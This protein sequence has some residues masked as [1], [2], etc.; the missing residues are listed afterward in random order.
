MEIREF[1]PGD[2]QAILDL[3][4]V[5]FGKP[6]SKEF[7]NWRYRENPFSET[8]QAH[9]MWDNNKLVG[10]YAVC[11]V[12]MII[13]EVVVQTA[14]SMTT[15]THPEYTGRGIFKDLAESLYNELHTNHQIQMVWGFPNLN[16]H[17]GFVKNLKWNDVATVPT[18][19][20]KNR[21]FSSF[22]TNDY[23]LHENFTDELVNHLSENT[24][25]IVKLDKTMDYLNWRYKLNPI[26][27]YYIISPEKYPEQF[28]VIKFF[29]S[30]ENPEMQEIDILELG[31]DNNSEILKELIGAILKFTQHQN[32][33]ILSINSWLNISDS[34][35]MLLEKNKFILDSPITILGNRLL[36]R[37][38]SSS[39]KHFN[40]WSISMGDSDVY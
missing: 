15:M 14:L 17:Y 5:S 8:T 10:H 2:E 29:Q 9:L 6:I 16:S 12:N 18:L 40:N 30:F 39:V 33:N 20:L 26:N 21:N 24:K 36:N 27:K 25:A 37:H 4:F 22:G 31:V 13:E 23:V 35:H 28:A 38:M 3:F 1:Q 11:P 7:W 19:K 34:R 32:L